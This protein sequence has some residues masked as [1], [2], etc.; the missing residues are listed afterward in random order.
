MANTNF[1]SG[2]TAAI[3]P[4]VSV[5]GGSTTAAKE[6]ASAGQKY[7]ATFTIANNDGA[8]VYDATTA[9]PGD[10]PVFFWVESNKD[11]QIKIK[12]SDGACCVLLVKA[13]I[14]FA[15]GALASVGDG[16]NIVLPATTKAVDEI[17]VYNASGSA[18]SVRVTA[19]K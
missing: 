7:D 2:F 1:Y 15:L 19:I 10:A 8:T 4:G 17:E 6:I 9:A 14:A 5:A 12:N 13:G 3:D 11:V 18:A 16:S